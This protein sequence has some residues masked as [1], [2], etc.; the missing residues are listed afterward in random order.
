M[1]DLLF[2]LTYYK[3]NKKIRP[4]KINFAGL[5]EKGYMRTLPRSDVEINIR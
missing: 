3:Y 4:D 5:L 2:L 1:K